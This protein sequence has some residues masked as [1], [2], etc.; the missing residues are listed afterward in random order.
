M[1]AT[2]TKE[3]IENADEVCPI[4][5]GGD[6]DSVGADDVNFGSQQTQ[7]HQD[8]LVYGECGHKF[9]LPCLKQLF[10]A[11]STA[12]SDRMQEAGTIRFPTQEDLLNVPTMG[13]CP[14]CRRTLRLLDLR[15]QQRSP[16]NS[17][18]EYAVSRENDVTQTE[19]SG[20]VF[21]KRKR[22]EGQE[23]IH[24]PKAGTEGS[25]TGAPYVSFEK[26][27]VDWILA[28]Q[29]TMAE[30]RRYFDPRSICFHKESRTFHGTIRWDVPSWQD[31]TQT[32]CAIDCGKRLNGSNAW[33]YI[34]NFSS[35]F[36]YVARGVLI[37]RRDPCRRDDCQRVECKF[38]LD[39]EW[40]VEWDPNNSISCNR[41]DL[42]SIRVH[43]NSV[44]TNDDSL[45]PFT[46]AFGQD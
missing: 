8:G 18:T 41:Q 33:E 21:L 10:A 25:E 31:L 29:T 44:Y 5:L 20:M 42:K 19:L 15:K 39:G 9:C 11:P 24:F 38:P 34:L 45:M 26:I 7:A 30:K 17:K 2:G 4:C 37:K 23:S 3:R 22:K 1:S 14:I 16:S 32:T 36:R 6:E 12:W 13:R 27:A 35:D 43:G 40:D 28:D 46:H